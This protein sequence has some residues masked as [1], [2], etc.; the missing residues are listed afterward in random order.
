MTIYGKDRLFIY[1]IEEILKQI[2]KKNE[3]HFRHG[4]P[5]IYVTAG[6]D[7]MEIYS[8]VFTHP[9]R[10]Y[11]IFISSERHFESLSLLFPG[12][13]KLCLAERLR[14]DELRQAL[15]VMSLLSAQNRQPGDTNSTLKL[16]RAE[17]QIMRLLLRG[18]SV[19]DIARIRGVSPTTV[20]VQRTVLMKRT[21]TK[22]LQEL[23]SLYTAM[24][25]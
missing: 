17:Q 3:S 21:G 5:T 23:C 2:N 1:G 6:M 24:G 8:L 20:S 12:L 9:P 11:S 15:E 10:H 18:H 16:T 22:S 14:V 25:I 4:E 7:I 19:D 13:V